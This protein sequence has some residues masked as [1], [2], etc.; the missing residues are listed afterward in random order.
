MITFQDFIIESEARVKEGDEVEVHYKSLSGG[1]RVLGKHKVIKVGVNHFTIDRDGE[2][3]K[4]MKFRHNGY[5]TEFSR[6]KSGRIK[7]IS[8]SYG[9]Y[10]KSLTE[11]T[12]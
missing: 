12:E 10:I 3:G 4:P 11:E 7:G 9:P 6:A 1:S 8:K 2:S 5:S